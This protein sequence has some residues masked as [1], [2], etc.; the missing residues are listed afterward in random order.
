MIANMDRQVE[1]SVGIAIS[2]ANLNSY[3][4]VMLV[5]FGDQFETEIDGVACVTANVGRQMDHNLN[6]LEYRVQS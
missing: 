6:M 2:S 1:Q 3:N 5:D 4:V